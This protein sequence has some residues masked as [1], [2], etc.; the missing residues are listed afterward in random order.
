M[1]PRSARSVVTSVAALPAAVLALLMVAIA[2]PLALVPAS[3]AHAAERTLS[4]GRLDWGIRSSFLTYITGPVAQGSWIL[5]GGAGTIGSGQF[6]FHSA[7]G[8]Y[9]P[10]TG[11]VRAHYAGGVHFV[12]HREESGAY[13]LELTISN[14]SVSL[15]G[16]S[17]TLYADVRSRDRDSGQ[18]TQSSRVA[19]ASL[20][21]GGVDLRGGS[22][23]VL[24]NVPATLTAE[25]ARAFAGYYAAGDPLDPV[26]LTADSLAPAAPEPAPPVAEPEP[27][28][29]REEKG[30]DRDEDASE[31]DGED[32]GGA[33]LHD[34]IVDWGVR[35]TFREFVTGPIADG[36]WNLEDGALD[37]GAL[38]RFPDGRGELDAEAGTAR[39]EFTG[40]LHFTGTGL[41]L[42]LE[43]VAVEIADGTGTLIA[44][45]VTDGGEARTLPV[46]TFEVP[47]LVVEDDLALFSE[48]PT[49]LTEEG[50]EVFGGLYAPETEMDPITVALALTEEAELPALPDLGAEPA[51][52]KP[53]AEPE[54]T[55]APEPEPAAS[56]TDSGLPTIPLLVGAALLLS[57][58]AAGIPLWRRR[59]RAADPTGAANDGDPTGSDPVGTGGTDGAGA[60]AAGDD[61]EALDAPPADRE[62]PGSPAGEP[63]PDTPAR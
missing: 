12:G 52:G 51:A 54:P 1:L 24:T 19:L 33:E 35:R 31:E 41:D 61:T 37:G 40:A 10:D 47:E 15:S 56:D 11:A 43:E 9:D 14:P 16:G 46:V 45:V 28:D 29:A 50:A 20:A 32:A 17:G 42:R 25:G 62:D 48:V 4:G 57:L 36:T 59:R 2:L 49:V 21:L 30:D 5:S 26:S 58:P 3:P 7:Q 8:T 53:V 34:A 22:Q 27:E 39:A 6:R 60:A 23:I 44:D 13:Q 63:V 18:V 38:F 55:P